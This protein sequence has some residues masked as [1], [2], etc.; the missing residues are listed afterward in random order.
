[1]PPVP[2]AP[3]EVGQVIVGLDNRDSAGRPVG[4]RAA[5]GADEFRRSLYIQ[6]RR[7]LP[8][9]MLEVF[10]APAMV[11][12]CERRA[13]TTV[14]P[15]ALL[16]MNNDFVVARSEAFAERVE[17]AAGGEPAARVRLA[18]R[19]A[20]AAEPDD[21]QVASAVAYLARQRDDFAARPGP[22]AAGGRSGP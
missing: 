4:K 10:D 3:D 2:V 6:V 11:P 15:Q 18:W 17:E 22:V 7:S 21:D 9:G 5:I 20:L 14:A 1:G 8:L 16:L 19:L 12:N 13:T